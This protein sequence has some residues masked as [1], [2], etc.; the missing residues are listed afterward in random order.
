MH[1]VERSRTIELQSNGLD[2]RFGNKFQ[3]GMKVGGVIAVTHR[4]NLRL[5]K[6]AEQ[7]NPSLRAL[8]EENK[9]EPALSWLKRL[10]KNK[11]ALSTQW[12]R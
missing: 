11:V 2:N 9:L 7:L 10:R 5:F 6:V 4:D 8:V 1:H 3:A 12:T